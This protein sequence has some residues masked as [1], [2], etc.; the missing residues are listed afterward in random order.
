M[1]RI[2]NSG[3]VPWRR[4]LR[5]VACLIASGLLLLTLCGCRVVY[6]NA[7]WPWAFGTEASADAESTS[8][9]S[10]DSEGEASVPVELAP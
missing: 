10:L 1:S 3:P 6:V 8:E 4:V 2:V 5:S 7:Q 9:Q